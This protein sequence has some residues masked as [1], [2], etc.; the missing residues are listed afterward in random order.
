[1]AGSVDRR[2]RG[3][4]G[5]DER[6]AP[7]QVEAVA[8]VHGH[9]DGQD[10]RQGFDFPDGVVVVGDPLVGTD[11]HRHLEVLGDVDRAL[12]A[13]VVRQAVGVGT[14]H[15]VGL[16]ALIGDGAQGEHGAEGQAGEQ[17]RATVVLGERGGVVD[18]AI[19]GG[20]GVGH[21]SLPSQGLRRVARNDAF[22]LPR[23]RNGVSRGTDRYYTY[24]L[25]VCQ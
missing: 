7:L 16:A 22:P 4:G 2:F 18:E 25:Y 9:D 23:L 1:M 6:P 20:G 12:E 10:V 14:D 8:L 21:G 5:R 24:T 19:Q 17:E 3:V 13:D 11:Q 15:K